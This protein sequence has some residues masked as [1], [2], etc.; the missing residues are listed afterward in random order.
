MSPSDMTR[1]DSM[2]ILRV[3]SSV[4]R[5]RWDFCYVRFGGRLSDGGFYGGDEAVS[6][7]RSSRFFDQAAVF[8]AVSRIR[9]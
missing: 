2:A 9:Q 4:F 7:S 3:G 8:V 1:R 5:N 6:R